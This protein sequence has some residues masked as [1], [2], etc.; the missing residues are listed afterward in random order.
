MCTG[1]PAWVPS[2]EARTSNGFCGIHMGS[3]ATNCFWSRPAAAKRGVQSGCGRRAMPG[4]HRG[5]GLGWHDL[6]GAE[7]APRIQEHVCHPGDI[8]L[9]IVHRDLNLPASRH[10]RLRTLPVPEADRGGFHGGQMSPHCAGIFLL[11]QVPD[12]SIIRVDAVGIIIQKARDARLARMMSRAR[13]I[14]SSGLFSHPAR[15]STV[16]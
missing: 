11:G 4:L 7:H 14:S 15:P 12:Q 2:H 5:L 1:K 16:E 10:Q 8:L 13:S 9:R 6:I 3:A